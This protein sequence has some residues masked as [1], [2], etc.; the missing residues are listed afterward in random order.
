MFLSRD[1]RPAK[2]SFRVYD[3]RQHVARVVRQPIVS[4]TLLPNNWEVIL[5]FPRFLSSSPSPRWR[6][7]TLVPSPSIR[8]NEKRKIRDFFFWLFLCGADTRVKLFR[9]VPE[10]R[11]EEVEEKA[12]EERISSGS[13]VN[14]LSWV[15]SESFTLNFNPLREWGRIEV[16]REKFYERM[17][18]VASS[19]PEK[20]RREEEKEGKFPPGYEN[21]RTYCSTLVYRTLEWKRSDRYPFIRVRISTS[22]TSLF[23][24]SLHSLLMY[25]SIGSGRVFR[26]E[27]L[28]QK[29]RGMQ[30]DTSSGGGLLIAISKEEFHW[31]F[32]AA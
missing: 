25:S 10:I 26:V 29:P 4:D 13:M 15:N 20:I 9:V 22:Y 30:I 14:W 6:F 17:K 7:T 1:T 28:V 11:S 3:N 31:N 5:N 27:R 19:I 12:V 2:L 8:A 32:Y 21:I 18:I 16:R 23:H 24:Y